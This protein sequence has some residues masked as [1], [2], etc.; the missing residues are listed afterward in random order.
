MEIR[1][2]EISN[3]INLGTQRERNLLRIT[4]IEGFFK[5][6]KNNIEYYKSPF[7]ILHELEQKIM[8]EDNPDEFVMISYKD[9]G[10]CIFRLKGIYADQNYRYVNYEYEGSVS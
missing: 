6:Y 1:S 4:N 5:S 8:Y 7:K 10:D 9:D 3:S 2:L